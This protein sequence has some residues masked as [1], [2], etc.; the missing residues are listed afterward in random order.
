MVARG[1]TQVPG[2]DFNEVFSSI[3]RHTS[4]IVLLAITTQ[5][6]LYLEQMD[7]TTTFLHGN[8]EERIL[9]DHL[10]GFEAKGKVEKVC[11]LIKS[12]YGLK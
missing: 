3:V 8:L 2:V 1:F 9:M 10:E 6:D 12:L 11:L 7:V 5:L 4:I